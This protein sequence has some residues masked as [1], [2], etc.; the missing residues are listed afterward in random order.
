MNFF[1]CGEI[2]LLLSLPEKPEFDHP[3]SVL[4]F[5]VDKLPATVISMKETGAEFIDEPHVVGK[6][7][8][9]EVWMGFL[10][11]TEGNTHAV[12]SEI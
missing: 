5:K 10:K 7:G 3:S 1:Q 9:T 12:M 6:M 4:Y 11:N 8:D 2:R